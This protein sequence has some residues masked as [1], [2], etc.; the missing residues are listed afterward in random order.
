MLNAAREFLTDTHAMAK[1][2]SSRP[3]PVLVPSILPPDLEI[4]RKHVKWVDE[5]EGARFRDILFYY[6]FARG[7]A[8]L[9]NI[10]PTSSTRVKRRGGILAATRK[11]EMFR[12]SV[13]ERS[14]QRHLISSQLERAH[15]PSRIRAR[16][17]TEHPRRARANL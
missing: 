9:G 2:P 10:F 8:I 11:H 15:T 4:D 5:K 13:R 1:E 16:A 7:L 14:L 17:F 3:P 6:T 12:V